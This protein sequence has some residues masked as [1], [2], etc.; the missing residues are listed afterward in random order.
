[1]EF[2]AY[3]LTLG[4][5]ARPHAPPLLFLPP[6]PGDVL[7]DEREQLFVSLADRSGVGVEPPIHLLDA[8]LEPDGLAAERDLAVRL[9]PPLL[10][11]SNEFAGRL[12]FGGFGRD[13]G[14]L[15]EGRVDVQEEIIGW[16]SVFV[17]DDLAQRESFIYRGEQH[18]ILLF[19]FAQRFLGAGAFER[20]PGALG[21]L[22]DEGDFLR[23]PALGACWCSPSA[24]TK[25]P[26]FTNGT[27][28]QAPMPTLL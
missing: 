7:E 4:R 14:H 9:D 11:A 10:D 21:G 8:V 1:M 24:A 5:L 22:L 25:R 28:T 12:A 27:P 13:S 18:V 2:P 15:L 16:L 19:R 26:P 6:A 20:R 17:Y 23:R 3:A